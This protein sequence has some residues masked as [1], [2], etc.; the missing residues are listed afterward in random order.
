M[1]RTTTSHRGP[2]RWLFLLAIL[3]GA[4]ALPVAVRGQDHE[5]ALTSLVAAGIVD[6]VLAAEVRAGRPVDAIITLDDDVAQAAAAAS[7][8]ADPSDRK[9]RR[10]FAYDVQ[11]ASLR[12]RAAAGMTVLADYRQMGALHVRFESVAALASAGAHERTSHITPLREATVSMAETL[13]LIEATT[14]TRSGYTGEGV[15]IAV[16]DTG[17]DYLRPHFGCSEQGLAQASCTVTAALEVNGSG[18]VVT[19]TA[20]LDDPLVGYHGT[21]VSAI[22][23][24]VA[25]GAKIIGI[26]VFSG[27][28]ANEG[29]VLPAID[30]VI[31][32]AEEYNIRAINLSIG[33]QDN[34]PESCDDSGYESAFA[35]LRAAG[36]VPVVA[37]GNSAYRRQNGTV[38]PFADG[39]AY[40]GCTQGA[41]TVG[42]VYDNSVGGLNWEDQYKLCSGIDSTAADKIICFSQTADYLDVL[43]PGAQSTAA[44]IMLGGT[45][46][47]TPHVAGAVAVLTSAKQHATIAAIE[48]AIRDSGPVI[49][50]PRIAEREVSRLDICLALLAIERPCNTNNENN[51]DRADAMRIP[52]IPGEPT[53]PFFH[54]ISTNDFTSEPGDPA[55]PS[56]SCT[57][58]APATQSHT[59]W[60]TLTPTTAGF[61]S[62]STKDSVYNALGVP[63]SVTESNTILAVWDSSLENVACNDN[64]QFGEKWASVVNVPLLANTTYYIEVTSAGLSPGGYLVFNAE[65]SGEL[66]DGSEVS[67]VTQLAVQGALPNRPAGV[68]LGHVVVVAHNNVGE[69]VSEDNSTVVTVALNGPGTLTCTYN[70]APEPLTKAV[71]SGVATWHNCV[72]DVPGDFTVLA[73]ADPDTITS[74]SSNS[75]HVTDP[76]YDATCDGEVAADDAL[77]VVFVLAALQGGPTLP[78][79]GDA[80]G[81]TS[82]S[83]SDV[84]M[85]RRRAAGIE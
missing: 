82:L 15:T 42:A 40:P 50:D 75:F 29:R 16:L 70:D 49:L 53:P 77:A 62:A 2:L 10:V 46:Q 68:V 33:D 26:D 12:S 78:C 11:K 59:A 37:A 1:T 21:N 71:Q 55:I 18:N 6:P 9:A 22:V 57:I 80:D 43:A 5:A 72:V 39:L 74:A 38:G 32:N 67:P 25:P 35:N 3:G 65:Y 34:Y 24:A 41:F 58:S 7:R 60:Y 51:D 19:N 30:W 31:Q 84:I 76:G 54:R 79:T 13:D 36:I 85:I 69:L 27:A 8:S 83:I 63:P 56:P 14:A 44:G 28:S 64:Y 73:T 20:P 52:G 23:S 61:F 48:S 81:D 66:S 17:L 4:L 45:S 47:A